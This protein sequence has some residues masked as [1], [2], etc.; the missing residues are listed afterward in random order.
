MAEILDTKPYV[1]H[2]PLIGHRYVPNTGRTLPRPGGG[3][4]KIII[5]SAGI[6]SAREYAK[7]KPAGTFRILVFGDSYAAGQFVSNDQRFTELLER[8]VSV[9]EVI[10]FGLEGTGTDQ[11]LLIYENVA[12]DYE[13]DLVILFPF[14]QNIRRNMVAARVARDPKTGKEVLRHK[15]RFELRDGAL[16]W[17]NVPVPKKGIEIVDAT[18]VALEK[19]DADRG[20][21]N[22]IKA[23]IS[24]SSLGRALKRVAFALKPWEPF[25]EYRS[26]TTSE[27][28]LMEAILS[29]FHARVAPRPFVI[30]PVF[31][32]SYVRFRMA[33]N[34]LERFRSLESAGVHVIDLLPHFRRLGREAS[35]CFQEPYDCHFSPYGHLVVAEALQDE[36][37]RLKLLPA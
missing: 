26:A 17:K 35:R 23:V 5:N 19:T 34:Y 12:R 14:L 25:P 7:S 11:Q 10:N 28:R 2:D 29:R 24:R 6:R 31:Y 8:R 4:Y 16:E 36:L 9:L 37:T 20:A 22:R 30:V 18:D 13:H 15:A 1:E 21:S 33:R 32:D 3:Q 27:W